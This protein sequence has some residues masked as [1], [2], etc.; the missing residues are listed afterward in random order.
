MSQ[1]TGD[2][3]STIDDRIASTA[4]DR[5]VAEWNS[6]PMPFVKIAWKHQTVVKAA[7]GQRGGLRSGPLSQVSEFVMYRGHSRLRLEESGKFNR[8][9]TQSKEWTGTNTTVYDPKKMVSK[10]LMTP[11]K[12]GGVYYGVIKKVPDFAEQELM[13]LQPVQFWISRNIEVLNGYEVLHVDEKTIR[14]Q[15]TQEQQKGP[16]K[17]PVIIRSLVLDLEKGSSVN[18]ITTSVV[19]AEGAEPIVANSTQVEYQI[20]D[21]IWCPTSWQSESFDPRTGDISTV[22]Y[23]HVTNIEFP[24]SIDEGMFDLSFPHRTIVTDDRKEPPVVFAIDEEGNEGRIPDSVVASTK[25]ADEAI[26]TV[27]AEFRKKTR[28]R[29]I[30][31]GFAVA[32]LGSSL[33]GG[34][35]LA[36][37]RSSH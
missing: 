4:K 30:I 3:H 28:F 2:L 21:S 20:R 8:S 19:R 13:W 6:P 12:D 29:W 9:G 11:I 27:T 7:K 23:S 33:V 31:L 35:F 34:L 25:S 15:S 10:F 32:V 14:L 37:K 1:V 5:I 17:F 18:R 16:S 36:A 22:H 24:K 26:A